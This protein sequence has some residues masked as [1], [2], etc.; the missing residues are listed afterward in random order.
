MKRRV[1]NPLERA[2]RWMFT[3]IIS[4]LA[5]TLRDEDLSVAQ[6]AALHLVDQAGELGQSQ[7]A[8]VLA[9]SPSAASRLVDGLVQRNLIERRES[10][11]DR[12]IRVL[13]VAA[14]GTELLDAFGE[15]RTELIERLTS[16]L[17]R[18]IVKVFLDNVERFRAEEGSSR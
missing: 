15:E 8:E 12:R 13:R 7:L 5:R 11:H 4:G 16:K 17:P 18:A 1:G 6:L 2:S 10:A 3:K 14:H 9:L